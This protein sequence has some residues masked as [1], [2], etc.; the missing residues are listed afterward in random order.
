MTSLLITGGM[1]TT[2]SDITNIHANLLPFQQNLR[3]ICHRSA[4][5][6]STLPE[7]HPLHKGLNAAYRYCSKRDFQKRKR[8]PSPLHNL[9][10]VFQLDPTK[11]ETILP[12]RHNTKWIPD[13]EISIA[14]K[15]EEAYYKDQAANEDIRAYSDGSAIDGGVGG[16]AVIMRGEEVLRERRFYLGSDKDHTVY[17]GEAVG[18]ILAIQLIKEE[19]RERGGQSL[20]MALGVDNQAAIRATTS[21]QS[22]PGHYLLDIFHDDLR[23]I[24]LEADGRK[25][26]IRWSAGHIGI[27]GNEAADEQAKRA[28]HGETSQSHLLPSSLKNRARTA[29][30]LPISKSALKQSFN[31]AVQNEAK[32]VWLRSPRHA[33]LQNIDPSAPSKRFASIIEELPR[34]HSALLFQ[35]RTGHVSLN[36]HLHRITKAP[37]PICEACNQKNESVYHFILECPAYTRHRNAMRTSMGTNPLTL[38]NLLNNRKHIKKLLTFIAQT[39]R[40]VTTHGDVSPPAERR[41]ER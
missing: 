35:L 24:L 8:H 19:L 22:K 3:K 15:T 14:S 11:S 37:S 26:K 32:E 30:A 2:A 18:M 28:A 13:V 16:G 25:L 23:S 20:T 5:R 36:K 4:L 21:Y 6:M 34:R 40:F 1:R 31:A 17:E 27:P 29:I 39:K 12:V 38:T 10:N 7:S 33:T 9:A 41:E